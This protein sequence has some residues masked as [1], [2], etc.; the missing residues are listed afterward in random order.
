M[1]KIAL[2]VLIT[3]FAGSVFGQEEFLAHI[4]YFIQNFPQTNQEARD[5]LASWGYIK[6]E[7]NLQ[8]MNYNDNFIQYITNDYMYQLR[9]W[10]RITSSNNSIGFHF[11]FYLEESVAF[12]QLYRKAI[13]YFT[14]KYNDFSKTIEKNDHVFTKGDTRF[15]ISY[16]DTQYLNIHIIKRRNQ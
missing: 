6:D 15:S 14:E 7:A 10:P 13:N 9:I 1:K 11:D 4:D 3:L 16:S 12:Y 2:F 8:A 5:K